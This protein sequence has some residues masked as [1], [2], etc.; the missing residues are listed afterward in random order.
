MKDTK[1]LEIIKA[2]VVTE[3]SEAAKS[4]GKYTFKVDPKANKIEIKEAIEK[5]F[6]VYAPKYAKRKEELGQGGGYTRI[7]KLGARRGDNAEMAIIEL[8]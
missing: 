6:N 4:E 5:I 8:V 2:P 7:L 1:Y 3:K